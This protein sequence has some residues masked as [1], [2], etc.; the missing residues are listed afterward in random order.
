MKEHSGIDNDV[1]D[2]MQRVSG[3]WKGLIIVLLTSIASFLAIILTCGY[4]CLPC[5]RALCIRFITSTVEKGS[6]KGDAM[7]PLLAVTPSTPVVDGFKE[8]CFAKYVLF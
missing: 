2:W 4:C 1:G 6:E 7:M 3:Q 5:I 8:N